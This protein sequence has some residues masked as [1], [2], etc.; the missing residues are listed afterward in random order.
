MNKGHFALAISAGAT[1]LITAVTLTD[2]IPSRLQ[3]W[4][5]TRLLLFMPS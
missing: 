4:H 3:R 5:V 1:A 2:S